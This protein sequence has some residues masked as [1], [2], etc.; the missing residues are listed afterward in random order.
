MKPLTIKTASVMFKV[1]R[2]TVYAKIKSGEL[3]RRP[4]GKLDFVEMLRVF[5]E[6]SD[7]QTVHDKTLDI[8]SV[9]QSV[10]DTKPIGLDMDTLHARIRQLEDDLSSAR[11]RELWL[12]G[13]FDKLTDTVKLLNAPT[14]EPDK[15]VKK[16]F[17]GRWFGA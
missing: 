5:G 12:Q 6:P 10:L 7:K 2:S 11:E 16:S 1:S 17:F 15:S 13:Q 8:S 9:Q 3:S 14:S 4:D